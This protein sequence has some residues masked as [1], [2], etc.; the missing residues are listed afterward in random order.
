MFHVNHSKED[1][2]DVE[3]IDVHSLSSPSASGSGND[4]IITSNDIEDSTVIEG[5]NDDATINQGSHGTAS[6]MSKLF[7]KKTAAVAFVLG[8]AAV[9]GVSI[10]GA[11]GHNRQQQQQNALAAING[12]G[13]K[14]GK[15]ISFCEPEQV[16]TCGETFTNEKVVLSSDLFCTDDVTD[17]TNPQLRMLNAAIKLEGPDAILDCKGHTVRQV[18]DDFGSSAVFCDRKPGSD[19]SP[20]PKR[21]TMKNQCNLYYQVGILLV[22]GATAIN[23]KV[24]QFYDGFF[25]QDGGEVKKSEASR[26]Y[27]GV[28]VQDEVDDTDS[29]LDSKIS[30]M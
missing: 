4:I 11:A 1:E 7:N 24:E 8:L 30:D 25:V 20:T 12:I 17:A 10:N 22:D 14:A 5:V 29:D 28:V 26:N 21:K 2:I 3:R 18:A 15:S 9:L 6:F 16:M 19:L 13:G 27:R 23:C